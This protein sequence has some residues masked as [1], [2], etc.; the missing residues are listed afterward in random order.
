MTKLL[1]HA[2]EAVRLLP[3]DQQDE[4]A[5]TILE[6]LAE[7]VNA[8]P[9]VLTDEERAAI[10]RSIEAADRGEFASD[11]EVRAVFAKYSDQSRR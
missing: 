9:Y 7:G 3:S 8:E 11:E 4:V 6:M 10:D 2:I 1:E 5:R